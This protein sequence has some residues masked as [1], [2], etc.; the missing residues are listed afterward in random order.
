[1][2]QRMQWVDAQMS[3]P[4]IGSNV[5]SQ[6]LCEPNATTQGVDV[7]F[8]ITDMTGMASISLLRAAVLDIAQA[9]VLQ[10]WSASESAFTWSDTD[11]ILQQTGQAYYWL[12][13]EPVNTMNGQ[14]EV[15]GPQ[16][17]L[18]NPSL[19]PPQP[20]TAISAS[21]AAAVNGTV[22]VT[23]NVAGIPPGGSVKIYATG[24]LGN[25]SPVAMAQGTSSPISSPS[26]PRKPSPDSH[27]REP[28]GGSA[29]RTHA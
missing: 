10:T 29:Q 17:I 5:V 13:L 16:F 19:L 22:L 3:T 11:K 18:L 23:C 9:T 1:M 24:Y 4:P 20:A 26:R 27:C 21:H 28:G 8:A 15:V 25:P 7:S 14:E 12:K 2:S 6:F